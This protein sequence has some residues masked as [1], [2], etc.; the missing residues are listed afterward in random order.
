M[1]CRMR[2]WIAGL[3][4]VCSLV[5][6]AH[7]QQPA[8]S[9]QVNAAVNRLGDL[10]LSIRAG[11][12]TAGFWLLGVGL[13]STLGGAA[14]AIAGHEQKALLA[15]GITTA[16]FGA[17]NA[18][19]SF[20]LLD[21]SE[22]H[23]SRIQ[24][25]RDPQRFVQL[26][27][28]EL[29]QQLESGQFFAV[30]T[31]LDVFYIATGALLCVIAAVR[32]ERDRWELGAGIASIGQGLFLLTFDVVNWMAANRRADAIRALHSTPQ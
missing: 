27:E 29:V 7:A 10:R 15:G 13:A 22:A 4:V 26:R 8:P 6:V 21:L 11:R 3:V 17:I 16:S 2:T 25:E 28:A 18:L 20:G 12:R 9:M 32:D 19:L 5:E 30:N 24:S 14:L 23:L 1:L 31:G